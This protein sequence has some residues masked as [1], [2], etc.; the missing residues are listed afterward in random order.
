MSEG[1]FQR[2]ERTVPE[3]FFRHWRLVLVAAWLLYIVV[4][5]SS[6]WTSIQALGLPDTD[7]NLR[8]AQVRALLEGQGWYDLTQHRFDPA[9]GGA[10]IHWS[11]LVD[12]PIAGLILLLK[13]LRGNG[14]RWPSRR[15]SRCCS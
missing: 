1:V 2:L 13:P 15:R 9:H 14:W 7:D 5:V 11:R 3:L 6:R 12:L 10:N 8:L 4:I